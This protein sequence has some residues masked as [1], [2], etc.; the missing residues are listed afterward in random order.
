MSAQ[1][2][3]HDQLYCPVCGSDCIDR[4]DYD[5]TR[6]VIVHPDRDDYGSPAGTRGGWVQIQLYCQSGH[7]F[8]LLAGNH[9]GSE[10]VSLAEAPE[11]Q[12]AEDARP[13]SAG[14]GWSGYRPAR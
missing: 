14:P 5:D 8:D 10:F 2:Y 12:A 7:H 6:S 13:R 3:A 11:R 4:L 1:V 9:K